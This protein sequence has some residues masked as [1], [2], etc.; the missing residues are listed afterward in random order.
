MAKLILEV[1]EGKTPENC[2]GCPFHNLFEKV[3]G[4]PFDILNCE[5]YDL[6]TLKITK[7]E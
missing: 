3:C 1:E 4:N 5:D 2:E 7:I 6:R